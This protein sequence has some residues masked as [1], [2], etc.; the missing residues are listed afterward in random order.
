MK[1]FYDQNKIP[2][3]IREFL[4]AL[5]C[6]FRVIKLPDFTDFTVF[7]EKRSQMILLS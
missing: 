5:L 4:V 6:T 7:Y 3:K 1:R 2:A